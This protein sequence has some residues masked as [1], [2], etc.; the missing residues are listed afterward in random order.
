LNIIKT[1]INGVLIFE[2]R[3][4]PDDRGFFLE[5]YNQ[6]RYQSAGIAETFVQDNHSKSTKNVLRGLHYQLNHPQAKLIY[7]VT[8]EIYDIAVDIRVGSPTFGKYVGAHLSAE[9]KR[10]FYVPTGFA[11]GF[12]VLS[13]TADVTYK[14]TDVYHPGDDYIIH[15]KCP[16]INIDWHCDAPLLSEKDAQAPN[17]S[18][19]PKDHLP[20]M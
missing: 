12:V 5:T 16:E 20:T 7:V 15:Y 1:E 17:L 13:D 14:C 3:C 10:Q 4:F 9:N 11:H 19:I 2:P 8:G 18:E 6:E